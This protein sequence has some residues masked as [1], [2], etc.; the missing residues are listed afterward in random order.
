M[1]TTPE[2]ASNLFHDRGGREREENDMQI[3]DF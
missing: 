3:H 2:A 1:P